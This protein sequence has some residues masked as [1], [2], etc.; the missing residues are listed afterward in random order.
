MKTL[1]LF[2]LIPSITFANDL[3]EPLFVESKCS[4]S[5]IVRILPD[6]YK[7]KIET[8]NIVVNKI[9]KELKVDPCLILSMVWV[10]STFKPYN[11]SNKG[12]IGLLQVMPRTHKAM[13]LKLDYKLNRM[14]TNGLKHGLSYNEL[15][16]LIIGTFY[17]KRLLKRFNGNSQRAII[18][19]NMGPTYVVRNV[20]SI[21]HP[22]FKKVKSK[23]AIIS[24][25]N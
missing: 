18:A 14:I 9:S 20:V 12:A 24:F 1:I 10:E 23:V 8:V 11:K 17:Y 21:N 6:N 25:N 7:D 19:Y 5:E 22:Y 2:L 16:N 13:S 3:F 15:E 4:T